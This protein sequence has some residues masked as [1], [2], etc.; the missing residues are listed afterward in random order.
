MSKLLNANGYKRAIYH[1]HEIL[2]T[3]IK[4]LEKPIVMNETTVKICQSCS[5]PMT[6]AEHKWKY[7]LNYHLK[8][9][10]KQRTVATEAKKIIKRTEK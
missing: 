7:Y 4:A 2:F 3:Y 5:M 6:V 8:K 10:T 1:Q 9:A